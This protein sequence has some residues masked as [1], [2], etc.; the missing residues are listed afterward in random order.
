MR[1]FE[2]YTTNAQN[3]FCARALAVYNTAVEDELIDINGTPSCWESIWKVLAA[4]DDF[5]RYDIFHKKLLSGNHSR[6]T[7]HKGVWGILCG[8]ERG[9]YETSYETNGSKTYIGISKTDILSLSGLN[10]SNVL[11]LL[12]LDSEYPPNEIIQ[13]FSDNKFDF[14]SDRYETALAEVTRMFE[15]SVLIHYKIRNSIASVH[16]YGDVDHY[17]LEAL[18][19][20]TFDENSHPVARRGVSRP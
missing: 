7:D 10:S 8:V 19:H 6:I 4:N 12:P 3:Y 15:Y 1:Y 18:I 14:D 16:L 9:Q 13:P 20:Q 11:L 5:I 17:N 2:H